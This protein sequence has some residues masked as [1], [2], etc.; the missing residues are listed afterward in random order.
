[1]VDALRRAHA[2]RAG[3]PMSRVRNAAPCCWLMWLLL[4][5]STGP[6]VASAHNLSVAHVDVRVP[7]EGGELEI[8]LDLALRD[9]ALSFPLDA[10]HDEWVTWGELDALRP[11]LASAVAAGL[12][13]NDRL[14]AC[15]LQLHEL[16]LRRY[17]DGAYASLR[18]L[19]QCRSGEGASITYRLLFDVDPQHRALLTLRANGGVSTAIA[20]AGGDG[21]AIPRTAGN[22]FATFAREG[23]VH[24]LGGYD[25]LAFLLCLLL[26]APLLR[27]AGRWQRAPDGRAIAYQVLGLVTAFTL[28]HSI[29]LAAAALGWVKPATVW[30]EAGI[31]A[32]VVLAALNN[33]WPVVTRR[34]WLAAFCFGLVHGL[35][36]AGALLEIGLPDQSRMFALLGF[37]LGVELGQL[38]VVAVLLPGMFALCRWRG[39]PRW[40][41]GVLSGLVAVVAGYW[42]IQRLVA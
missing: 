22:P 29:T 17:D 5:L 27:V 12:L 18:L 10:N 7:A 2:G 14:G 24:I 40:V 1:M 41:M 35:G 28:A 23:V 31:A 6:G 8:E 19:A 32:S 39:Y 38:A 25:H 4:L 42:L 9:L 30:V 36:F 16:G 15:P 21:I 34:L 3:N 20:R 26:P 13:V 11:T 37:N 33:L